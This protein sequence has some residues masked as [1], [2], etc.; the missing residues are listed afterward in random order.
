MKRYRIVWGLL[1]SYTLVS[2]RA[3]VYDDAQSILINIICTCQ[4]FA[5][6]WGSH[7]DHITEQTKAA[8]E[9]AKKNNAM[10]IRKVTDRSPWGIRILLYLA[11]FFTSSISIAY[12]ALNGDWSA[13]GDFSIVAMVI[14]FVDGGIEILIGLFG[15]TVDK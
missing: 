2:F 4:I 7:K 11:L 13:F 8:E 3:L 1:L 6:L 12:R 10:P 14:A 5:S 9:M 15:A